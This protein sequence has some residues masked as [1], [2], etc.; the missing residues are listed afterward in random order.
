MNYN[1]AVTQGRSRPLKITP[2]SRAFVSSYQ[3]STVGVNT[4]LSY[5]VNVKYWRDKSG[6][7]VVQG[8]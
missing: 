7:E 6:L 3:L 2:M 5:T 1:F 8:H 4:C